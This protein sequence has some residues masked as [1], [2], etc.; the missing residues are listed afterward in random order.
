MYFECANFLPHGRI[1]KKSPAKIHL[2][3][4]SHDVHQSQNLELGASDPLSTLEQ[5]FS[6]LTFQASSFKL[7]DL[8]VSGL[9][10]EAVLNSYFKLV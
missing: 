5:K 9:N 1:P 7:Q 4:L 2:C 10:S 8:V 6:F 3:G